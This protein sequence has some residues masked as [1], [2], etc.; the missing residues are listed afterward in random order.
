MKILNR[1]TGKLII[2]V[3]LREADLIGADLREADLIEADLSGADLRGADLSKAD[4][5]EAD[6]RGAD[7]SKAD[8]SGA[9]LD[10]SVWPLMCTSLYAKVDFKISAQLLYHAFAGSSIKPT[11]EQ[12]EFMAKNFH[13]YNECGG[14]KFFKRDKP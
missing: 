11:Q 2:E 4:L 3:D 13:R 8:L 7:L 12:I 10:Y 14:D 5:R 9:D 6:L 1:W